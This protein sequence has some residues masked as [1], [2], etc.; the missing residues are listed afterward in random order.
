MSALRLCI[1]HEDFDKDVSSG[2]A[3]AAHQWHELCIAFGVTDLAVINKTGE[4]FPKVNDSVSVFEIED[5]SQLKGG[6]VFLE[7][8]DHSSVVGADISGDWLVIGG[9]AGNRQNGEYLTIPIANALY[10]REAAAIALWEL[11]K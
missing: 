5:V 1:H 4:A 3:H 8:G 7:Q 2:N 11:S 9:A 6:V 10:P